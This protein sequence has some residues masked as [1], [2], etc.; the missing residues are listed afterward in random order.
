MDKVSDEELPRVAALDDEIDELEPDRLM[1][2]WPVGVEG[3]ADGG[4][5][6]LFFVLVAAG[7]VSRAAV[8]A[9]AST[10]GVDVD[11][12]AV[13]VD[14]ALAFFFSS[15]A[16]VSSSIGREGEGFAV[17]GVGMIFSTV[18]VSSG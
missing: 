10:A 3:G 18:G 17:D 11:G 13:E 14:A 2:L 16:A 9:T 8:V 12:A 4:C 1:I 6:V 15:D 7:A 5:E